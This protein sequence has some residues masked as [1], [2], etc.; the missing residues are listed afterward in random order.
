M[1]RS[2]APL[3]IGYGYGQT[4]HGTRAIAQAKG[5]EGTRENPGNGGIGFGQ[6]STARSFAIRPVE[7]F[8]GTE[9]QKNTPLPP[10]GHH[11]RSHH[12]VAQKK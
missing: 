2:K 11:C 1:P 8:L 3:R 7:D 4:R 10:A 12:R 9:A 6:F 5:A